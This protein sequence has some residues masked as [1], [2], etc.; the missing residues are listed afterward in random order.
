MPTRLRQS[1]IRLATRLLTKPLGR[2]QQRATNDLV[3]LRRH[4]SSPM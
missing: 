4:N 3:N 2:Y 1:L